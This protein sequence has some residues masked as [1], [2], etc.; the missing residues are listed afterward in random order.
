MLF[1]MR[2]NAWQY[3]NVNAIFREVNIF[4]GGLEFD[5]FAFLVENM[6]FGC[7]SVPFSLVYFS[8]G[9]PRRFFW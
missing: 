7:L 5:S 1:P 2:Q 4:P 8:A 6:Y 3:L 9:T